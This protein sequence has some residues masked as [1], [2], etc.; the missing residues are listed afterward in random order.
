MRVR[1]VDV[2]ITGA[3]AD[4]P[5]FMRALARLPIATGQGLSHQ[6]Y[7][8]TKSLI[9]SLALGRGYL[10]GRFHTSRLA[11]D[12]RA[13]AADVDIHWDRGP[14]HVVGEVRIAQEPA[15]VDEALVAFPRLRTRRGL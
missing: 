10:D 4:D 11:V 6:R 7:A 14:R 2:R 1:K 3:A 12:P 5:G 13:R 15:V 8:D 9:E